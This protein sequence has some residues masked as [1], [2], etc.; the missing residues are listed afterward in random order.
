M[1]QMTATREHTDLARELLAS[2]PRILRQPWLL[3]SDL[4]ENAPSS[5][6]CQ[7][8]RIAG[9]CMEGNE[10]AQEEARRLL[11][12]DNISPNLVHDSAAWNALLTCERAHQHP[13]DALLGDVVRI[14]AG[15]YPLLS[16]ILGRFTPQESSLCSDIDILTCQHVLGSI[17]PQ[18][19]AIRR[20]LP[21]ARFWE[22]IGKPYSANPWVAHSLQEYG[23][24]FNNESAT[25][26]DRTEG[27]GS[28][29][30]GMYQQ[31]HRQIVRASVARFF[32]LMADSLKMSS[33]PILVIDDGG[34][35]IDAVGRFAKEC[36]TTRPIVCIE[37]TQRGLYAAH[38][39][40]HPRNAPAGGLAVVNVAQ[41]LSKLVLESTLI[42]KSVVENLESW[43]A[44]LQA[45][46]D[47]MTDN[48]DLKYGII[49]FGSV[50]ESIAHE[51]KANG[52]AAELYDSNRNR[53]AAAKRQGFGVAL[54][55]DEL[56]DQ[57]GVVIAA[58]G[59]TWL[60]EGHAEHLRDGA[61]LASASSGDTEFHGLPPWKSDQLP[62]LDSSLPNKMFDNIH[63]E[64]RVQRP[65]GA[66]LHVL[67]GGFP[68][69]FN[70]SIDPIDPEQIQLTRALMFAGVLHA[71]GFKG[72]EDEDL[73]GKTGVFDLAEPLDRFLF[74]SYGR[75]QGLGSADGLAQSQTGK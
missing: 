71:V 41:T 6:A 26:P 49:G 4:L 66:V 7:L 50:G 46:H 3:R 55:L 38:S 75:L 68:V 42:A 64:I 53:V 11:R 30:L 47:T 58:T 57:V 21:R 25:L 22:V 15:P 35:L 69:N 59:G 43:L 2:T 54:S 62:I 23:F 60:D 12:T 31:R 73:V 10:I 13:Y 61:V 40:A 67:N 18:F 29:K 1:S 28:Y 51:L 19:E 70:G 5:P 34:T 16:D 65:D 63:G 9:R 8:L 74:E 44:E 32:N 72:D 33:I 52:I 39:V 37:Q 56:L 27:P 36:G 45:D 24:K 14:S 48:G 17:L 20:L